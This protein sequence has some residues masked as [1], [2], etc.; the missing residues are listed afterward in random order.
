[1]PI[2][3]EITMLKN[4]IALIRSRMA[5]AQSKRELLLLKDE[6]H[7]TRMELVMAQAEAKNGFSL[8]TKKYKPA[9]VNS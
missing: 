7:T 1:M 8:A 3:E 4:N 5:H 6:L 2:T 9:N